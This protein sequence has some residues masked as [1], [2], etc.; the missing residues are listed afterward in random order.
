MNS[1][2]QN[3][4]LISEEEKKEILNSL[5]SEFFNPSIRSKINSEF[6]SQKKGVLVPIIIWVFTIVT[7]VAVLILTNKV[8]L[9]FWNFQ[10]D[11]IIKKSNISN[12][13]LS[14]YKAEAELK[15][16]QKNREVEVF[17]DKLDE[18]DVKL[19]YLQNLMDKNFQLP[20]SNPDE[21]FSIY[22]NL[23]EEEIAKLES[24]KADV[25]IKLQETLEEIEEVS[26]NDTPFEE[27]A[28]YEKI[29]NQ[30]SLL[31]DQISSIYSV[32]LNNLNEN[33]ID[34]AKDN[35]LTLDTLIN[36]EYA[37]SF[38]SLKKN[39]P[40]NQKILQ[41]IGNYIE[42]IELSR[43]SDESQ[44]AGLMARSQI[45][46]RNGDTLAQ[47]GEYS[48][49]AESY[50][51]GIEILPFISRA[52]LQ[53]QLINSQSLEDSFSDKITS[54]KKAYE[55]GNI[56]DAT[57]KYEEAILSL[58]NENSTDAELAIDDFKKIIANDDSPVPAET[59]I[60]TDISYILYG[61]IRTVNGN[62]VT[63]EPFN[64][65]LI[66]LGTKISIRR[67]LSDGEEEVISQGSII[68][69][70]ESLITAALSETSI[71]GE[72]EAARDLVYIEKH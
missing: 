50:T 15:I 51:L 41:F 52:L 30:E 71:P 16:D 65:Q 39:H 40:Q 61:V 64:E 43:E 56:Q 42:M 58:V 29:L 59:I 55:E 44:N 13:I 12:S 70:N 35:L 63:I 53:L 28:Y 18:Y 37:M 8:N 20:G 69:T 31:S 67:Y 34:V 32:I 1:L 23:S 46:I 33:K 45:L 72:I 60:E 62:E 2:E 6:K 54:A 19:Q 38:S 14:T 66:E 68:S 5:D 21:Q 9:S 48:E 57:I 36:S 17:Q 3:E 47:R 27:F 4:I 25:S 26:S 10:D 7:T 49:A 24:E 22:N 11:T